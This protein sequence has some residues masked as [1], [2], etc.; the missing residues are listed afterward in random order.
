MHLILRRVSNPVCVYDL[1]K[2]KS[3]NHRTKSFFIFTRPKRWKSHSLSFLIHFARDEISLL[4]KSKDSL[5]HDNRQDQ[6]P[7]L[8]FFLFVIFL[9]SPSRKNNQKIEA[10]RFFLAW[11]K[12]YQKIAA[13]EALRN[14]RA[15]SRRSGECEFTRQF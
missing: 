7:R 12:F 11:R 1:R 15:S 5:I 9:I 3:T 4:R 10:R 6:S 8:V 2:I 13:S 14:C